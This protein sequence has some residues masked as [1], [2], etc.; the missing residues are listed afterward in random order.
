[1]QACFSF[2]F[3]EKWVVDEGPP[4]KQNQYTKRDFF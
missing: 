3:C 4:E 1:M 2:Q